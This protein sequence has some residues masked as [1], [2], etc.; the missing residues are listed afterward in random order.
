MDTQ[1]TRHTTTARCNLASEYTVIL[2][3]DW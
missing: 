1:D 3:G 2:L